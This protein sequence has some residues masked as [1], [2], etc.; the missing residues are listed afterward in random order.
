VWWFIWVYYDKWFSDPFI[1]DFLFLH[2]LKIWKYY[3]KD[4]SLILMN[5]RTAWNDYFPT[6]TLNNLHS[7]TYSS[8]QTPSNTGVHVLNCLFRTIT[9]SND[10]GALYCSTSVTYLLIE[11]T[12]FISC[13]TSL[14]GGAIHFSNAN[15]QCVLYEVC[16]YDCSTTNNYRTQF[17]YTLVKN[18]ISSKNYINYSTISRCV[19]ENSDAWYLLLLNNGKICCPS[20]NISM[21]KDRGES[22]YFVPSSDSNSVTCSLSYSSFTD[23]FATYC[24][25]IIF[26]RSSAKFEIKSCNILRNTQSTLSSEGTIYSI[27]ELTISDSW[28]LQN[29]ANY[30]FFQGS[31]IT[32]LSKCT[33]D[34]T[35]NNKNLNTQNIVTKSFILALDHMS[36]QNCHSQYDAIGTLTPII[37][38]STCSI[39]LLHLYTCEKFF[40]QLRR[41]DFISLISI[42]ISNFMNSYASSYHLY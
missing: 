39:R 19:N 14:N 3:W 37:Q 28:I 42:S 35:S 31:Y 18:G 16:G 20:V 32:T 7:Q 24:T 12:S 13:K 4:M 27:G 17:V 5:S 41:I 29:K 10:G 11:S 1:C 34:S 38:P 33:V 40:L 25:C 8:R 22:N 26:W 9:S 30:I 6:V 2:F 36:T 23:N 15:G 21:N